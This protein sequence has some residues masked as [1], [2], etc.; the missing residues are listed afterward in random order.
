MFLCTWSILCLNVPGPEDRMLDMLMRKVYIMCLGLL[1]PEFIFQ[2]ALAQ[3][4]S[5]RQSIKDFH[6]S[7][8]TEWTIQHAFFAD[9]GGFLLHAPDCPL[10][11]IDAKQLHYL[12]TEAWGIVFG[13]ATRPIDRFE[14][15]ILP[16]L[17][18]SM[19]WMF[20]AI[21][22]CLGAIFFAGWHYSFPTKMEQTLWPVACVGMTFCLMAFHV[23]TK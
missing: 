7:G 22:T 13:P 3:W 14:N 21:T 8:Y 12:V 11:P 6:A 10:F 19:F 15:T 16:E 1:G 4:G 20:V 23:I 18:E 5:A 17:S 9:M 2:I